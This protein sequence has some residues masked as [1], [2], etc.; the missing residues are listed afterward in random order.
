MDR[1]A[2]TAVRL[3]AIALTVAATA[4]PINH[5]RMNFSLFPPPSHW[6]LDEALV[7]KSVHER[8]RQAR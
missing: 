3:L 1:T 4:A 2:R 7:N 8:R 5:L 6:Q